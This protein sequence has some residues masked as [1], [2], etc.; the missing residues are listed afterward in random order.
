MQ[1]RLRFICLALT[2]LGLTGLAISQDQTFDPSFGQNG[3]VRLESVTAK[4]TPKASTDTQGRIV[5][6]GET[7]N[8]IQT[9]ARLLPNGQ[10]DSSF[11]KAG[12]LQLE[13]LGQVLVDSQSRVLV[14]QPKQILRFTINGTL[15]SSYGQKGVFTFPTGRQKTMFPMQKVALNAD[16]SVWAALLERPRVKSENSDD[17]DLNPLLIK[18][19]NQGR[20]DSSLG[21]AGFASTDIDYPNVQIDAL[22]PTPTGGAALV[23]S[24]YLNSPAGASTYQPPIWIH[25]FNQKGQLE[26]QQQTEGFESLTCTN[27]GGVQYFGLRQDNTAVFMNHNSG[28]CSS[29]LRIWSLDTKNTVQKEFGASI[30]LSEPTFPPFSMP[31]VRSA[32]GGIWLSQTL[33]KVII[34]NDGGLVLHGVTSATIQMQKL[35]TTGELNTVFGE[36]EIPNPFGLGYRLLESKNN[37]ILLVGLEQGAWSV[38]QLAF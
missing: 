35:T 6:S 17:D 9:I 8:K 28:D 16:G 13:Q 22:V 30:P 32:N 19:T 33:K 24:A 7:Q 18:I 15:D 25:R 34:W 37:K 26:P 2:G 38:K 31:I 10:L 23:S 36:K 11:G 5:L 12:K 14:V 20:L 3:T 4:F 27:G 21:K 1:T 29:G